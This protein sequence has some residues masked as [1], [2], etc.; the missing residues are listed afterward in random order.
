[1]KLGTLCYIQKDNKTLLLHRIKKENDVH[2]GKWIG[3]GGKFEQG[4]TPEE[5]VIREI[6]EE[7]GLTITKPILR[8]VMTFP[9]FKDEEDWYVFVFTVN[10][11]E[12]DL[13]ESNEGVLKWVDNEKVLDMPTWEGDRMFLKWLMD[14]KEF[15][16]AKF[17]YEDGELVNHDVMFYGR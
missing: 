9:L 3:L 15:F 2:E 6:K 16:S 7:S 10:E 5:C 14:N 4:E 12:G 17:T 11:F 13:I 8:G 1:M